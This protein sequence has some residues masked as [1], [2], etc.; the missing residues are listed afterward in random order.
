MKKTFLAL[1]T[2]AITM[3]SVSC[4][5]AATTTPLSITESYAKAMDNLDFATARNL[6][7]AESAGFF[8]QMSS[9]MKNSPIPDSLKDALKQATVKASNQKIINDSTCDVDITTTLAKEIMGTK[10]RTQTYILKKEKGAWKV[11]LV[12]TMQKAME[13][14]GMPSSDTMPPSG[15]DTSSALPTTPD[16]SEK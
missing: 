2:L 6:T 10:E 4:K 16:S 14:V 13:E 9:A 11:D 1:A 8:D 15:T 7:T 3:V 5:N 12:A